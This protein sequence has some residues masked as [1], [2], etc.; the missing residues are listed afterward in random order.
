PA[1]LLELLMWERALEVARALARG[2]Q[3]RTLM[4]R[5]GKALAATVG[6]RGVEGGCERALLRK[7]RQQQR[8][9][10]M[11]RE[12]IEPGADHG[13][14]GFAINE[15]HAER[16][17]GIDP[18]DCDRPGQAVVMPLDARRKQTDETRCGAARPDQAGADV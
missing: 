15:R 18:A 3:Q 6:Q 10:P 8:A 14:G 13:L 16:R 4:R 9:R 1:E 12:V 11:T 7:H 5:E 17:I 2:R